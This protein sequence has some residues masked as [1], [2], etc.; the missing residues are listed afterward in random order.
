MSYPVTVSGF[1]DKFGKWVGEDGDVCGGCFFWCPEK[2][3]FYY[4]TDPDKYRC[5]DSS[6]YK[7]CDYA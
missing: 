7:N 2:D 6:Q 5:L 3:R 4:E 1:I